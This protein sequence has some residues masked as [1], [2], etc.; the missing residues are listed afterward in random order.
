VSVSE[1]DFLIH[2]PSAERT[3]FHKEIDG[4]A[5]EECRALLT[6]L[7]QRHDSLPIFLHCDI[8]NIRRGVSV[9]YGQLWKLRALGRLA[10]AGNLAPADQKDWKCFEQIDVSNTM[11][12]SHPVHLLTDGGFVDI[13]LKKSYHPSVAGSEILI[14][15]IGGG[16]A[17]VALSRIAKSLDLLARITP[18]GW[19]IVSDEMHAIGTLSLTP[20]LVEGQVVSLAIAAV[21]GVIFTSMTG[22]IHLAETILHECAHS[23]LSAATSV[24]PFWKS[25]NVRLKTPLRSDPRPLSGLYHQT[26]VLFWLNK[27]FSNLVRSKEPLFL[28]NEIN[29]IKRKLQVEQDF[30]IAMDV[31]R[32]A[33]THLTDIGCE[34]MSSL[35]Q[36]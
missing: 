7:E 16:E 20:P 14:N 25:T 22:I 23:R 34:V 28:K 26:Y 6:F 4:K 21:P 30:Y 5:F 29:V 19:S 11:G 1:T 17:L 12:F 36:G 8:D 9:P 31:L 13:E 27:F 3:N 35:A 24:R 10:L 33:S 15:K 2:L 18:A 32:S